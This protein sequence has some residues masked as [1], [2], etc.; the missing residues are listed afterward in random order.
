MNERLLSLKPYP[1][2]RLDAKKAELRER[3][4]RMFDFGTGDPGDVTPEF[5]RRAILSRR[6]VPGLWR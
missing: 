2:V 4:V 3:G 6:R 1:K 5:I